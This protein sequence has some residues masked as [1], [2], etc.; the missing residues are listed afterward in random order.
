M[1]KFGR[2]VSA[3]V[4][5]RLPRLVEAL[6]ADDRVEAVWLF[7]SRARN[8]ADDLSDVDI[9]VLARAD[10]DRS[11]LWTGQREWTGLAVRALGTDEVGVQPVNGLPVAIRH[12]ILRDARL[13]WSRLPDVAAD[14]AAVALKE[15]L[16]LKPYHYREVFTVPRESGIIGTDLGRRLEDMASVRNRLV[17]GY[18]D[19]EPDRV[20]E[21]A[22][23][24][25]GD[26]EAFVASIVTR[27]LPD[28]AR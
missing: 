4:E 16:D 19:V 12:A 7:G 13:L 21:M 5:A 3:D 10:L 15:Y 28:A 20:H 6:A 26:V 9:A 22:R 27:F 18:L 8:E 11:A 25:L 2:R 24:E 17:H 14:F 1:I 23:N